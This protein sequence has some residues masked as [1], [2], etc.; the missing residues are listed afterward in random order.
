M[1]NAG[2]RSVLCCRL[3]EWRMR[4]STVWPLAAH[5][6][7]DSSEP[8]GLRASLIFASLS[9]KLAYSCSPSS[10]FFCYCYT[11]IYGAPSRN[12]FSAS[13]CVPTSLR[14]SQHR[15]PTDPNRAAPRPRQLP[16]A[17]QALKEPP[18]Y[19]SSHAAVFATSTS[20]VN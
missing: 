3:G 11:R 16:C 10:I 5:S 14:V 9:S 12:L 2:Y 7:L 20:G 1:K 15:R 13:P 19:I 6:E 18:C 8:P 17:S 4:S